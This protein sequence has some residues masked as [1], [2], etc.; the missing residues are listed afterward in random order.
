MENEE[1]FIITFPCWTPVKPGGIGPIL[2]ELDHL[3]C[4]MLFTDEDLINRYLYDSGQERVVMR[5]RIET[6][7]DLKTFMEKT[8]PL[9]VIDDPI[10]V[11]DVVPR[12][13]HVQTLLHF[14][15]IE[16]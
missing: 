13:G 11:V 1:A 7:S 12:I 10:I 15:Q 4:V 3:L 5:L 2:I 16:L 8:R 6:P 14:D 9:F